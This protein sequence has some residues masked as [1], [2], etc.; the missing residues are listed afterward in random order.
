LRTPLT[1]VIGL[2]D[3]LSPGSVEQAEVLALARAEAGRLQR[4][5]A[6]LLDMVR[7][8]TGAVKLHLEPVDLAEAVS[9]AVH[10][11]RRM[12]GARGADADCARPAFGA[13]GC[14][15]VASLP[16]QPDPERGSIQSRAKP[17]YR[18][19]RKGGRRDLLRHGRRRRIA[20]RQ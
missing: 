3:D 6:N 19:G 10:D 14:A 20:Y 11:L 7:I 17:D 8:E 13:V 18:H 16:N 15:I 1:A 4:F 12:L 2:L 5:V 9:S